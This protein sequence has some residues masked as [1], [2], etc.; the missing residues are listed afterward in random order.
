MRYRELCTTSRDLIL[1]LI[2][3]LNS[4]MLF[5]QAHFIL[6]DSFTMS[7]NNKC[8]IKC[9]LSSYSTLTFYN[10]WILLFIHFYVHYKYFKFLIVVKTHN[11]KFTI[12]AIFK[13]AIQQ[14]SVYSQCCVADPQNFL[15]SKIETLYQQS[16]NS[17]FP[18]PCSPW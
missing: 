2:Y 13:C 7:E 5:C 15:S 8:W 9:Y 11:I 17:P 10:L 18:H 12:L 4:Y 3:P 16:N 1:D 14:C 6:C